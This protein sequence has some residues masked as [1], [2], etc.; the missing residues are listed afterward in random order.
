VVV[1]PT[2]V[3]TVP[4]CPSSPYCTQY[5]FT[6][7]AGATGVYF[8]VWNT[9]SVVL[10]GL[11]FLPA[12]TGT[13]RIDVNAC[14]I[15]WNTAAGTCAGAQTIVLSKVASGTYGATT[16]A[17][18]YPAAVG[19]EVFLHLI[20]D[21][22]RPPAGALITLS[23]SVCSGGTTCTDGTATRQIRAAKTTNA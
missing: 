16:T 17:G 2:T 20:P 19:G 5:S 11:S 15:P 9:G 3:T 8:N 18:A 23:T 1:A 6:L 22:P 21:A 13:G 7:P 14:S 4:S 10:A 12:W